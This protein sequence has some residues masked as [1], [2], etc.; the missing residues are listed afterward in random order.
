MKRLPQLIFMLFI[1]T[2][3]ANSKAIESTTKLTSDSFGPIK[4]K[5]IISD[6]HTVIFIDYKRGNSAVSIQKEIDGDCFVLWISQRSDE[7]VCESEK[8][9]YQI[10]LI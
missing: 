9:Q 7:V 6:K 10:K 2:A 1:V 4:A 8:R 3:Q 5:V